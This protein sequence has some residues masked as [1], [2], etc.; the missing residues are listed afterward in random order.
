MIHSIVNFIYVASLFLTFSFKYIYENFKQVN[1]VLSFLLQ[2]FDR[3]E[4][5]FVCAN[6]LERAS[7]L[8]IL[9]VSHISE[10]LTVA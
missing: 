5:C 6:Y 3:A 8:S 1:Y 9:K 4:S 10:R 7:Y 2:S